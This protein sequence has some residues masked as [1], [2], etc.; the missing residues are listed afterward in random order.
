MCNAA[1]L[2]AKL[3]RLN[4]CRQR[5]T[6]SRKSP[7][8]RN[9]K[10]RSGLRGTRLRN[11]RTTEFKVR[12]SKKSSGEPK[13]VRVLLEFRTFLAKYPLFLELGADCVPSPSSTSL[14]FVHVVLVT[15]TKVS[16]FWSMK[17]ITTSRAFQ[18][19]NE[20]L[21]TSKHPKTKLVCNC[22]CTSLRTCVV[23]ACSKEG[24][25]FLWNETLALLVLCRSEAA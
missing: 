10:L 9:P 18:Q 13:K 15:H 16:R 22:G 7:K 21:K 6:K 19:N 14:W 20:R 11:F 25:P 1:A 12:N 4:V 23:W 3:H 8:F 24:I 2:L 17:C 5:C